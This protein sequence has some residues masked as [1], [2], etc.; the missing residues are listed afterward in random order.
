MVSYRFHCPFPSTLVVLALTPTFVLRIS[1]MMPPTDTQ[2][3]GPAIVAGADPGGNTGTQDIDTDDDRTI[4][5]TDCRT[6]T[7]S[8][9][10]PPSRTR[11]PSMTIWIPPVMEPRLV[12]G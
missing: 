7:G 6:D 4:T 12:L 2:V 8:L 10:E 5:A 9:Y 1:L 11:R 3:N